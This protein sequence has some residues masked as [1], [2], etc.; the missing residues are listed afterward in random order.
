VVRDERPRSGRQ[1]FDCTCASHIPQLAL[2]DRSGLSSLLPMSPQFKPWRGRVPPREARI[3]SGAN[4]VTPL[5]G[6][7]ARVR[8]ACIR[9]ASEASS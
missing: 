4:R 9:G 7:S 1:P 5:A 6:G 2:G 8:R 3:T